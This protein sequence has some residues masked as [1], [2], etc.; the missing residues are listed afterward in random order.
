MVDCPRS[1]ITGAAHLYLLDYS[2]DHLETLSTE[3]HK[4]FPQTQ[5]TFARGDA[6]D[7][8]VVSALVDQVMKEEQHLDFFFANAGILHR[9]LPAAQKDDL[10]TAV[11]KS[12]PQLDR[13]D[14]DEIMEVFRVNVLG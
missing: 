5:I 12:I 6:A 11:R 1:G 9:P 7:S 4:S 10:A 13:L 8:K 3:I 14:D 2:P